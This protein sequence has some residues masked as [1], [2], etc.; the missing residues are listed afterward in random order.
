MKVA[1]QKA[2]DT[3]VRKLNLEKR[4]K[5]LELQISSEST[6][7]LL[8]VYNQCENELDNS[9]NYFALKSELV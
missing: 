9:R 1:K 6:E 3:K 2:H 7:E 4:V 8:Q 5:R